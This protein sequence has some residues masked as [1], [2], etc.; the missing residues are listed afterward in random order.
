[1]RSRNSSRCFCP[2]YTSSA[3]P[4]GQ[5][6]RLKCKYEHDDRAVPD[7]GGCRGGAGTGLDVGG[8]H[9]VRVLRSY[10]GLL[11]LQPHHH[12]RLRRLHA[13][14]AAP[15][16]PRDVRAGA[17]AAVQAAAQGVA[18]AGSLAP[19]LHR[20]GHVLRPCAAVADLLP[21][22]RSQGLYTTTL[23][24]SLSLSLSCMHAC[25][26]ASLCELFML[27]D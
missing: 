13:R 17:R 7:C 26:A 25:I 20:G 5:G 10:A 18:P 6:R 8:N 23:S 9:V 12:H 21:P 19:V 2:T 24:L 27:P 22:C 11:A 14:A 1:V 16:A 4:A 3:R 15:P